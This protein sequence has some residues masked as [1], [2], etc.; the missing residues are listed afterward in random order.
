[1]RAS[2]VVCIPSQ[3]YNLNSTIRMSV[4]TT[5]ALINRLSF[6]LQTEIFGLDESARRKVIL[7]D[8]L[9]GLKSQVHLV[10]KYICDEPKIPAKELCIWSVYNNYGLDRVE[11]SP[12]LYAEA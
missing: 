5:V 7:E 2:S 9:Q 12:V 1:M 6:R 8:I 4:T 10:V 11:S 3:C